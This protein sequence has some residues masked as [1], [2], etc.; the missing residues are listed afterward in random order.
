MFEDHTL[1][2]GPSGTVLDGPQASP[3]IRPAPCPRVQQST[4]GPPN[5]KYY[6]N[7][8]VFWGL[9]TSIILF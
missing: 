1:I 8:T 7:I 4:Y 3:W 9:V 6:Y 5:I 2:A